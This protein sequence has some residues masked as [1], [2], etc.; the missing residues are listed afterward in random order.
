MFQVICKYVLS[1][2]PYAYLPSLTDHTLC[3]IFCF[4]KSGYTFCHF[5]C[6]LSSVLFNLIVSY[7]SLRVYNLKVFWSYFMSS[8][9]QDQVVRA[10]QPSI[11]VPPPP[12][13]RVEI[14]RVFN[15]NSWK[16]FIWISCWKHLFVLLNSFHPLRFFKSAIFL[17]LPVC[18]CLC[19]CVFVCLCVCIYVYMFICLGVPN[20]LNRLKFGKWL[21]FQPTNIFSR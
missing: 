9:C 17:V 16:V 18:L 21:K 1:Y 11:L 3:Y 13:P 4:W 10:A 6:V 12:P 7:V 19:V 2:N 15:T 20:R 14:S 8:Q 5:F